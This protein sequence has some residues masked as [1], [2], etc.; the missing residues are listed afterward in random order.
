MRIVIQLDLSLPSKWKIEFF[1]IDLQGHLVDLAEL[2]Y[3]QLKT[4]P[5]V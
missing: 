2:K 5:A 3:Q 4:A 1:L